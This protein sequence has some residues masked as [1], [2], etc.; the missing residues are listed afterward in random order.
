MMYLALI[1]ISCLAKSS[2]HILDKFKTISYENFISSSHSFKTELEEF[3]FL[4]KSL[5]PPNYFSLVL[6]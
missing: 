2:T 5:F 4:K 1:K 6:I 3:S